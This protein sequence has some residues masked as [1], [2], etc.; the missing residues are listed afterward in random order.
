LAELYQTL[1]MIGEGAYGVVRKAR[2]R[3]AQGDAG[4]AATAVAASSSS[5]APGAAASAS[6]SASAASAGSAAAPAGGPSAQLRCVFALARG[7]WQACL[8]ARVRRLTVRSEFVAIKQMKSTRQ[9]VGIPQDAYREIKILKELHHENIVR[10]ELVDSLPNDQDGASLYLVY[11]YAE[12]DL[13]DIIRH[14][15]TTQRPCPPRMIKSILFQTLTGLEFLHRNWVMHRD[16]KPANILIMGA[17]P[18]HGR[19]K[20]GERARGVIR[21]RAASPSTCCLTRAT[22]RS[23]LWSGAHFSGRAA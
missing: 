14:H 6:A 3:T 9:G 12:H 15:R 21:A 19:V 16:M 4:A 5:S 20:I 1:G 23:R 22:V 13:A 11:D 18:E 10:L 2:R 17:G 8:R 7:P